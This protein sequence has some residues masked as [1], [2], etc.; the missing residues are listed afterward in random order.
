[1]GREP[2]SVDILT[3]IPGVDFDAA[4]RRRVTDLIDPTSG[5]KASFI[6]ADDLIPGKDRL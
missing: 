5:L 3:A 2:V 4:W 6:S 1:M